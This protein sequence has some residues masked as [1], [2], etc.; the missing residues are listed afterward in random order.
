MKRSPGPR[1]RTLTELAPRPQKEQASNADL[2]LVLFSLIAVRL[3]VIP[4]KALRP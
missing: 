2:L 3:I 1:T 4:A